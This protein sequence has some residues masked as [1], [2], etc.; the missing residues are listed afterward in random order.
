M[1]SAAEQIELENEQ[2]RDA[3]E[4][5]E[6]AT[7]VPEQHELTR[8]PRAGRQPV[9]PTKVEIEDHYPLHLNYRDR[10]ERCVSGKPDWHSTTWSQPSERDS[11]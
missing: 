6:E 8:Q 3:E 1:T 2:L 9:L 5:K 7:P 4:K 10:C 11:A